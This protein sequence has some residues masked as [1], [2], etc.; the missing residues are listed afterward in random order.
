MPFKFSKQF[1]DGQL[2]T[3]NKIGK[4]DFGQYLAETYPLS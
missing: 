4:V 2:T 1:A 3:Q